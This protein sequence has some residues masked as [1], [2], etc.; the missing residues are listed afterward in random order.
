LRRIVLCT[1]CTRRPANNTSCTA[2]IPHRPSDGIAH[3]LPRSSAGTRCCS[4]PLRAKRTRR[5]PLRPSMLKRKDVFEFAYTFSF[6]L[7]L[8]IRRAPSWARPPPAPHFSA[9]SSVDWRVT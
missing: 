2:Y 1:Y 5:M 8:T 4:L 3:C 7:C 9:K 6:E